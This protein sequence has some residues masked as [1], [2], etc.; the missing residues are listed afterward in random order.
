MR[1]CFQFNVKKE[2][3]PE[4]A[5]EE[6]SNAGVDLLFSSS[7]EDGF[8][9]IF[10]H[11]PS[12]ITPNELLKKIKFIETIN[13]TE[14][15]TIDWEAQWAV[16]GND[17][18]EGCVH[19]DLKD[20]GFA[21]ANDIIKL[22]PGAGF[23][24]VSHPTTRLM[25]RLMA[26]HIH[27][28]NVVDVGCGSGV[29]SVCS[30]AMGANSVQGLDI[31]PLAIEHTWQNA[32]LNNMQDQIS[33]T[34]PESFKLFNA[35]D[36]VFVLMNMISSEQQ[37]AWKSLSQLHNVIGECITSGILKADKEAYL[38]QCKAWN[39]MLKEEMEEDDWCAF[40]FTGIQHLDKT[41]T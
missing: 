37:V 14:L 41:K 21:N 33:C 40:Y 11:L 16:H 19:I 10:G 9:D 23:G 6:L 24:D 4:I 1:Q 2:V 39:W 5:W 38:K 8:T 27:N 34:L 30:I 25:L 35:N 13:E 7:S 18:H 15:P 32:L 22:L 28:Q 20:F 26:R 12:G 17:Y 31:D 29:L 3:D 36:K